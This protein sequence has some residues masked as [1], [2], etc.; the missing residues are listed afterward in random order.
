VYGLGAAD[1]VAERTGESMEWD[2]AR[3]IVDGL[4]PR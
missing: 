3:R 1:R 2:V 4:E